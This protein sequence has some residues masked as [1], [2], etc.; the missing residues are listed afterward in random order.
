MRT[1]DLAL[2]CFADPAVLAQITPGAGEEF[3]FDTF[4]EAN[5]SVYALGKDRGSFGGSGPLI[6][7]FADELILEA[8]LRSATR[9]GRRLDPP[10]L[11][12]LDESPSIAP[13][14]GLPALV[15]DGRGRAIV[16][17]LAMQSFSQAE[18]RWGRE[19]AR[20]IRNAASVLMIFGGLSVA[21]DLEEL[22]KLCGTRLV[23]HSSQSVGMDGRS[24]TSRHHVEEPVLSP[25]A[26]HGLD[27]GVALVL[28][29]RLP[30]IL[31]Y[32]PGVW[33][34]DD[35]PVAIAE[36]TR[37]RVANDAARTAQRP[38][39]PVAAA[40]RDTTQSVAR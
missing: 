24:S 38:G 23:E 40:S 12:C 1:V 8:E 21:S 15:A 34:R 31:S 18:A 35:G 10:L 7:A 37:T 6:T 5:A 36:E 32:L 19:D 26:I 16:V 17:L 29:A 9:A 14:P 27:D 4:F 13:L 28:F 22:S 11:A 33:E 2:A 30:P 20:T 39:P 3:S 25:A